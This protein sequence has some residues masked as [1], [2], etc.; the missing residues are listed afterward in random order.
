[1]I[2]ITKFSEEL[3]EKACEFY[4]RGLPMKYVAAEIGVH[5]ATLRTWV[6]KGRESKRNDNKYRKF[7]L[8]WIRAKAD[9][10]LVHL[11]RIAASNDWRS[12]RYL[13]Q[14]CSPEDYVVK[15]LVSAETT[16]KIENTTK[17]NL[18]RLAEAVK[19]IKPKE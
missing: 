16:T 18:D 2:F 14:I 15:K 5:P 12:S 4:S 10:Q 13:L 6:R 19:G 1:M 7:Y 17:T 11:D 3:G 8:S 9:Y